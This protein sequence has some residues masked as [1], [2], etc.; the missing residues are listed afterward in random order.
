[1]NAKLCALL[2]MLTL[3][4]FSNIKPVGRSS[5]SGTLLVELANFRNNRGKVCVSL[6]NQKDAFPKST[7][8]AV[9]ISYAT[10]I[11]FK[12]FVFFENLPA[13]EYAVSALHDENDNKKMDTNIL[14][15]PKEGV[16]ASND[17]KGH[18][19]PPRYQDAKFI[20]NGSK[21][22]IHIDITYI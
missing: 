5:S 17:A 21:Q 15:I 10:I 13:G 8:K 1:M 22:T 7:E 6:F 14:G 18:L 12:S 2:L 19:G 16:G 3:C 20:F 4:G 11:G 9:R